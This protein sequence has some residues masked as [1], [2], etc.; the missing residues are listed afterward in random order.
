MNESL[1]YD[2]QQSPCN[3]RVLCEKRVHMRARNDPYSR[4][5]SCLSGAVVGTTSD[6]SH[7][8]KHGRRFQ[9][10]DDQFLSRRCAE[11]LHRTFFQQEQT[12]A[13]FIGP[14]ENVPGRIFLQP[15]VFFNRQQLRFRYTFEKIQYRER[16]PSQNVAGPE[17]LLTVHQSSPQFHKSFK[18]YECKADYTPLLKPPCNHL[19][20]CRRTQVLR[21]TAFADTWKLKPE[22]FLGGIYERKSI[23][24]RSGK[25]R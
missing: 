23:A 24:H 3:H 16:R 1:A 9:L 14:K 6:T 20:Q 5:G 17:F 15:A 4:R 12:L 11:R 13:A 22:I 7:F 10:R 21:T 8:P 19:I 18:P 2:L 25:Q